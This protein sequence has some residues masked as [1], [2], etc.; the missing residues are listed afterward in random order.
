M[1]A[2]YVLSL[3]LKGLDH[4]IHVGWPCGHGV[5]LAVIYVTSDESNQG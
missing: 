1:A 2:M 4:E 3:N 5:L